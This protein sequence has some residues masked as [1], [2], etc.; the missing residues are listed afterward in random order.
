MLKYVF[1]IC[2]ILGSNAL[3][4]RQTK[5]LLTL[6]R[7]SWSFNR[8]VIDLRGTGKTRFWGNSVGLIYERQMP[9]TQFEING[10]LIYFHKTYKSDGNI[11]HK[12]F[13]ITDIASGVWKPLV[14]FRGIGFVVGGSVHVNVPLMTNLPKVE[15]DEDNYVQLP[16]SG[17]NIQLGLRIPIR[18]NSALSF[19]PYVS[20]PIFG[21]QRILSGYGNS[22]YNRATYFPYKAMFGINATI[23]LNSISR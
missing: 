16:G 7:S 15:D 21:S 6:D 14:R 20:Y 23:Q 10:Q 5:I 17:F 3:A 22:I 18:L 12:H 11:R 4:Q 8:D 13:I 1:L 19:C 9:G 2:I